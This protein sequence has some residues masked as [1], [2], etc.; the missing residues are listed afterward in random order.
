[1][2]VGEDGGEKPLVVRL[3]TLFR[4]YEGAHGTHGVP[5][6]KEGTL[7]WEI[8]TTARTLREPVTPE[9]WQDHVDGKSP[10]GVIAIREDSTCFWGSIDYDVYDSNLVDLLRR[11]E[12]AKLPLVPCRSKSGGLHLFAF[13]KKAQPAGE[14]LDVLKEVAARLGVGGSEVFPRQSR[15]LQDR[16]D[17]GNWMVMPYFGGTYD[18]RIQMQVGLRP[19]GAELTL[20]EFVRAAEK[21]R[22]GKAEFEDLRK[23]HYKTTKEAAASGGNEPGKAFGDGPPC[24]QILAENGVPSG[25][26]NNTLLM[27]GVY[28]KRAFPDDW[29]SK[30][31]EAART[32]LNPPGSAEGTSS[33]I[34]SLEKKDYEYTCN[35]E[36]MCSHCNSRKCRTRRYGVGQWGEFPVLG[37]LSVLATEPVIWF[38]DV[39]GVRL[40]LGTA[41]LQEY[42]RFH[43]ACMEKAQICY[44]LMK[45]DSWLKLVH[46]AMSAVTVIDPPPDSKPGMPM[47]D[48]MEEFLTNR[49]TGHR[50]EDLLAGR[51][52]Y[53]DTD[54]QYEFRLSDLLKFLK[55]EG[56]P[57]I[58]RGKLTRIIDKMGGGSLFHNISGKGV[59]VRYV[60]AA[61]FQRT[62]E[63]S[64]PRVPGDLGI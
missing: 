30:V 3:A 24:L 2:E 16:G 64:L 59:N 57:D 25:S 56:M 1:M 37:G 33:V 26:Q 39:D 62:P 44:K 60:P 14:V 42:R 51:P 49:A 36:P 7:K 9:L 28:Y 47:H 23:S 31:E 8:K 50:R 54:E 18:G 27:M 38:V 15:I 34:R 32:Y 22:L 35:T 61:I 29:K 53:N 19:T 48:A 11:V 40:E 5:T 10:L 41:D 6:L 43:A 52:W 55:R 17:L 63:I 45:Q 12:Q 21:A 13:F 20:A 46:E 58:T 4:G